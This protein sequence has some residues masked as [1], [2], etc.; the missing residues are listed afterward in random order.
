M[1]SALQEEWA[2]FVGRL[3]EKIDALPPIDLNDL[4]PI[5]VAA[6]RIGIHPISL[7]RLTEKGIIRTFGRRG[8]LKVSMRELLKPV[9]RPTPLKKLKPQR[10]GSRCPSAEKLA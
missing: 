6:A 8:Y 7:Y 10:P 5:P 3:S 1:A 9:E 4:Q 2:R